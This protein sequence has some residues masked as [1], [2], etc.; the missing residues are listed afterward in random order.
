MDSIFSRWN[1]NFIIIHQILGIDDKKTF[2]FFYE[3]RRFKKT[4]IGSRLNFTILGKT[5]MFHQ[6]CSND[7]SCY[8]FKS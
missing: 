5:G 6:S 2:S 8:V 7:L 3:Y 4:L 1:Y